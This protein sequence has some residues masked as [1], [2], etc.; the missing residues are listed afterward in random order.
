MLS[1]HTPPTSTIHSF[2]PNAT[3][4]DHPT[5]WVPRNKQSHHYTENFIP[6]QRWPPEVS[7]TEYTHTCNIELCKRGKHTELTLND[8]LLIL[9]LLL[10]EGI[11]INFQ[12]VAGTCCCRQQINFLFLSTS[13][14]YNTIEATVQKC[15][16]ASAKTGTDGTLNVFFRTSTNI[17]SGGG[18]DIN[19]HT[20]GVE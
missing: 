14:D 19:P 13:I 15:E 17:L 11:I 18:R 5:Y 1:T 8:L 6:M 20:Q 3:L 2:F 10:I 4:N 9:F 12:R 7:F 16:L